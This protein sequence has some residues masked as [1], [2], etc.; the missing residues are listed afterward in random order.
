MVTA[1]SLIISN[2]HHSSSTHTVTV[3]TTHNTIT[4][5]KRMNRADVMEVSCDEK[6]VYTCNNSAI[7]TSNLYVSCINCK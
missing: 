6:P 7:E 2:R 4:R 3:C 1:A 5:A